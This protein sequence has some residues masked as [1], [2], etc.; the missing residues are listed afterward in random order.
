M[1]RSRRAPLRLAAAVSVAV[2]SVGAASART[3]TSGAS[4]TLPNA[5][6]D[7]PT[8]LYANG[9]LLMDGR[10]VKPAGTVRA[11]GDLP[12]ASA[13]SPDGALEAVVN[14]GEGSGG[15]DQ[16]N[17]SLQLVRLSDTRVVQTVTDHEPGQPTFYNAGVSFS[18]DGRHLYVTGGGNDQ[19]YDYAVTPGTSPRVTLAHRWGSTVKTS[20][21]GPARPP[22]GG[23]PATAQLIGDI[24]GY[25]RGLAVT[26]D[27]RSIIVTNEQGGSVVAIDPATGTRRWETQLGGIAQG[28]G[29]YPGAVAV[30]NDGTHALVT[31]QGHNAVAVL[32]VA[33]GLLRGAV[34]VGDHPSAVAITRNSHFAFVT[35]TND[36][37]VSIL[38]LTTLVPTEVRRISVHLLPGEANGSAPNGIAIDS[39]QSL[40]Y[41]ADA[42]DNAVA[43]LGAAIPAGP[44]RW[45]PAEFRALGFV[46]G[47]DYP[48]S[49]AIVGRTGDL[50]TTSAKG[51]GGV[52]V[53]RKT[54]YDGN[55]MVGLLSRVQ[56]PTGAQLAAYTSQSRSQLLFS[57]TANARRPADSPIPAVPGGA[58]PIKHVVVIVR[59]NRTFDQVFGDLR[60]LGRTNADVQPSFTEFG[61]QN[62]QGQT[63]TPNAHD[64]ANRFALSQNFYSDGE[65][66]IQ[67]HHW[68][69]EGTSTDYTEKSWVDYYSARNHPYD[70]T[71]AIVYPRCGAIFQQLAAQGKTFRD[72]GELVGQTTT[73]T[74]SIPSPGAACGVPGG[75]QDAAVAANSAPQYPN[76]L[77]LT[78]VKDTDRLTAFKADYAPRVATNTVPQFSYLLMG[79]DHTDGTTPGKTTP[80]GL[81]ATNDQAVGGVVDYL[82]H[83]KDLKGE[84][85][86]KSTAVFVMEDDSQDGL[87]HRDGHRNIFLL[88]SPYAAK[89]KLSSV[90]VSQASVLHTIELILGLRPLSN[91][92]QYA[93]VPYDMFTSHPD[94]TPY[95]A[96]VPTYPQ[97]AK[98]PPAAAG[99][100]ASVPTNI[101]TV[102]VA[103]PV[104]EAQ[105]WQST[106]PGVPMPAALVR[107][108]RA[109][110]GISDQ[111][112]TAWEDGNACR[113]TALQ[114]G[115]TVAPGDTDG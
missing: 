75:T 97:D 41:V 37:T 89:G 53:L 102:D 18:P 65:A 50:L 112:L 88:A 67:G 59:E 69:A 108:L 66:S 5:T 100:A 6:P 40:V 4:S 33:T 64:L 101:S 11:L 73:Q 61:R 62:S 80:Q 15:T 95:T 21:P 84:S 32:D 39:A 29:A 54:Q 48:T 111:A 8:G 12:V 58:T 55:D 99:T 31:E 17:Q 19:V 27:G 70:P 85:L 51:Y 3:D 76:N 109:R 24:N 98:N 14:G 43:V 87:D 56:R 77:F 63:V 78:S 106:H 1:P 113:C 2:L 49:V 115:L 47:A 10:L 79:N 36:D 72:F 38:D 94:T 22:N 57:T 96:E 103:G 114:P 16:G 26:P 83:A 71:A 35:N 110:G 82:S 81:V 68:T 93:P 13:V 90:H 105:L 25:S 28:A 42:G 74:P 60:S 104:L 86:W 20:P 9:A 52:P 107:E 46:P 91:Y 45:N 92:T 34:P 7:S 23:V 30:S 44:S